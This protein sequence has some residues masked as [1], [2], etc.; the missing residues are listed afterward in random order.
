V[1]PGT[2]LGTA[3]TNTATVTSANDPTPG[4]NIDTETFTTVVPTARAFSGDASGAVVN[5]NLFSA[6]AIANLLIAP[7]GPLPITGGRLV[8]GV[9]SVNL[10]L[11]LIGTNNTLVTDVISTRTSGGPAGI[12]DGGTAN[13]S[14]SQAVVN[15]LNLNLLGGI[16][17]NINVTA[18]TVTANSNCLCT[19]SGPVC[20]GSSV[21]ENLRV[22]GVLVD[23]ALVAAAAPNTVIPLL[24]GALTLIINEQIFNGL[25]DITVNALRIIV[26]VPGVAATDIVIAQAHSDIQCLLGGTTAA[27]ATISGRV[28]TSKGRGLVR[29]T[30]VLTA[31]NG[32][33]KYAVTNPRGYYRFAD[34]EV[35]ENYFLSVRSKRYVYE[36][37][38]VFVT[39]DLADID[40][41][42]ME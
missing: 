30:V 8:N 5:A 17:G 28:L 22:N 16:T 31:P 10:L 9:A 24:G 12:V 34:L 1:A 14:Q 20:G 25:G 36:T 2:P 13:T 27:S 35:G 21:I 38:T 29:A 18:N 42:P 4:N 23:A 39:E 40:F 7:T 37:K 15:N 33:V 41:A 6:T 32:D 19:N 26:N 3:I 11:G